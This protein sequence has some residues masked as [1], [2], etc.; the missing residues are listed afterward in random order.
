MPLVDKAVGTALLA[1]SVVVFVYY[2]LWAIVTPFVDADHPLQSFFPARYYAIMIPTLL[3]VVG[4]TV[5]TTFVALVL[6]KSGKKKKADAAK[7]AKKKE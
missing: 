1:I 7:A 5:A 3:L 4:I 6:I 2:T